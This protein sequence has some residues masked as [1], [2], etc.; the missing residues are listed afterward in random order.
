MLRDKNKNI[1]G[2]NS[3]IYRKKK[4]YVN[5]IVWNKWKKEKENNIRRNKSN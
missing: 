5:I 3:L 2:N 1:N 4:I